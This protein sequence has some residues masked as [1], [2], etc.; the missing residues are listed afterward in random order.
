MTDF[1]RVMLT[2]KLAW[3]LFG[4][5]RRER[6]LYSPSPEELP[7]SPRRGVLSQRTL[8][9]LVLFDKV[10]VH[11]FGDGALRIPGLESDGIL[12]V[13]SRG[14]PAGPIEPLQTRWKAGPLRGRRK[15]PVSLL[16]S[17]AL[18]KEER[19]LVVER[20]LTVR[21]DWERSLAAVLRVSRREFL[22]AFFDYALACVEGDE[23][24]LKRI[25]KFGPAAKVV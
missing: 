20:L 15:P 22:N 5:A 12:Q 16:R 6:M 21:S 19:A 18:F 7:P 23:L 8:S 2:D 14:Q 1:T 17:L 11:E 4:L 24:V 13:V 3:D 9:F 10:F 25:P